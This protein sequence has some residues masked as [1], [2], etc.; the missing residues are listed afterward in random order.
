MR[1]ER[2]EKEKEK[3]KAKRCW[4]SHVIIAWGIT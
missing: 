4:G 3:E 2:R 1:E